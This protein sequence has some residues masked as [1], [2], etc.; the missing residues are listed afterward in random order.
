MS[1][2]SIESLSQDNIENYAE[3]NILAW[4]QTYK[5][6]ISDEF[7]ELFC[8]KAGKENIIEKL[9][10]EL[11]EKDKKSFLLK[12]DNEY[13]GILK[14]RK[15]KY[16]EYSDYGELGAI[17]LLDSVKGKGYGKIL[18]NKAVIELRNMG[19][20]KMFNSCYEG[21]LANG[22]YKHMNGK[23]VESREFILSNGEKLI[24][25]IYVYDI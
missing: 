23:L 11:Y 17:Y 1:N 8:S 13:V 25:N 3:V 21:N 6:I 18:F 19:Y 22:F 7:I 12:V 5:G 16:K 15:S 4:E 20:N 24:E 10:K 9:K 2:Y 14:I